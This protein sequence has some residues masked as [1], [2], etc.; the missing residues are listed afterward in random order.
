MRIA[1]PLTLSLSSMHLIKE[2]P[3]FVPSGVVVEGPVISHN[4]FPTFFL[5]KNLTTISDV[6]LIELSYGVEVDHFAVESI[7]D[8]TGVES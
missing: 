3:E 8:V 2:I 4:I 1:C 5:I 7:S 6:I